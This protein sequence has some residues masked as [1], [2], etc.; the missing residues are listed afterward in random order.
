MRLCLS[1]TAIAASLLVAPT[2]MAA[3]TAPEVIGGEN[4][5]DS[6]SF[7]TSLE[8]DGKFFCGGSLVA[9]DWVLT[10][11]HCVSDPGANGSPVARPA[12]G[13]SARVGSDDRIT[14]GSTA[15]VT[16]IVVNPENK[17]STADLA[18]L[19]L[20]HAVP[21]KPVKLAADSAPPESLTRVIGWGRTKEDSQDIPRK[22]QELSARVVPND[23]CTAGMD[24]VRNLCGQGAVPGTNLCEGDSGGPQFRG[25]PG[26]WELVGVTSGPADD[27]GKCGTGYGQW[28]DVSSY[29]AWIDA[30]IHKRAVFEL[31][32][33]AAR[34]ATASPLSLLPQVPLRD[35]LP[36]VLLLAVQAGFPGMQPGA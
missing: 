35:G 25:R 26:E 24:R 10:A 9:P 4:A 7:M 32:G 16:Q 28:N 19:R 15:K 14:G 21:Q 1:V 34:P 3:G 33:P 23:R 6:Y 17:E 5:S 11:A 31:A 20:D 2:A 30:T 36:A 29:R 12:Q 13:V 18:L 22:L 8:H 27:D